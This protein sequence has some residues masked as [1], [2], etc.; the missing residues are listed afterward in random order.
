ML[1][2]KLYVS[3][4]SP[5]ELQAVVSHIR[6]VEKATVGT[7]KTMNTEAVF[8]IAPDE[9]LTSVMGVEI[10]YSP[11]KLD[12]SMLMDILFAVVNPYIEDQSAQYQGKRYRS[13]VYYLS[14]EDRVQVEFCM[15]FLRNRGKP[16]TSGE[17]HITVND[18]NTVPKFARR[19]CAQAQKIRA[20]QAADEEHQD[21]LEKHPN[22]ETTIDFAKLKSY[23]DVWKDA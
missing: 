3:G 5:Y 19:F 9:A 2:Q 17:T 18:P 7:I 12:I 15:N 22:T 16:P 14:E 1:T 4:G 11:K 6:G 23:L 10:L 21:Y 8:G 20:F 13:G